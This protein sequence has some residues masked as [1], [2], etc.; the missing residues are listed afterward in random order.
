MFIP[1]NTIECKD[2]IQWA[3]EA[4]Q[5]VSAIGNA[6]H[7]QARVKVPSDLNIG[8]WQ[9]ICD[10]YEDQL[11]I[12]YLEY[13]FPLHASKNRLMYNTQV[14]NHVSVLQYPKEMDAYF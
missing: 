7:I 14:F 6:N 8:N 1:P 2:I 5:R 10:N 4:H 9:A 12:D 13:G 3:Y 11:I